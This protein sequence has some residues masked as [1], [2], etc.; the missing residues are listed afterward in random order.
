MLTTTT[1]SAP[2]DWDRLD[3]GKYEDETAAVARLLKSE[4]LGADA[5][6]V[7]AQAVTLV[8]E[9]RRLA[10]RQGVVE[11]FLQEFGLSTPEGLALMCLAE[12]L[13]RTPDEATRDALIAEKI[14]SADW[15]RHAGRSDS[16]FVNAGT[17]GLMLTGRLV[18]PDENAKRALA[19]FL[20]GL[21]GRIGEPVIRRAVATA[22]GVMGDQFVL[23]RTIQA[24]LKRA[25]RSG[26]VCSFDMLGEGARTYA[27]AERYEAAY[28]DAIAAVGEAAGGQGPEEGHGISVKLSAL[29][30][31]YEATQEARVF[32]EL[33]PR[34]LRIV[35]ASCEQ[36]INLTLDA[37][38][39]DRLA[40]SLK[41][42]E[43]LAEAPELHPEWR[44]LGLAVQA[45]QKR[46]GAVIDAVAD[47]ARRSGRRLMVRLVKGAYWDAEIKSAQVGGRP[48]YP[49]FTTKAATDLSYLVCADRLLAAAPS[50]YGQFAT[51][52]AHTL[53][54]VRRL[55]ERR[56]VRCERQRPHGRGEALHGAAG[57]RRPDFPLRIYA[58]VGGH[59]DLLP[60]L[61]R[62]LLENGANTSFVNRIVDERLPAQKNVTAPVAEAD[63]TRPAAEPRIALPAQLFGS[64]RLNSR[65][66]NFADGA[67]LR[68]LLDQCRAA[69][70]GIAPLAQASLRDVDHAL[71]QATRAQAAWDSRGSEQRVGILE[72]AADL[73]EV[74]RAELI[75]RCVLEAGRSVPDSASEVREAIDFLRYYAAQARIMGSALLLNGPTGERNTLRVRGR[76]V[77]ACISPWNFPI[78]IFTG[79]VSAA[80]VTGNA[81]LA[82]PAEQTPL[83]AALAVELLHRAGV[84]PEVLHLLPGGPQTGEALTGDP[85]IAGVVFTGSTQTARLIERKLAARSGAIATLIAETGGINVMI[86]DSSALA[87]QVV[88]DSVTSAF[89]SAGQRCSALRILLLRE[90]I[91]PT[92]LDL[93]AGQ[94]DELVIGPSWQLTTDVGPVIDDEALAALETYA[95]RVIVGARWQHRARVPAAI[96]S[97]RYFR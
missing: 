95:A 37:E 28:L 51:H 75:A 8:L 89:N 46:G 62:R 35:T 5:G 26:F 48:D 55:A 88:L 91:A 84:P 47:L 21:A 38:E 43:K 15:A 78:S 10:R 72:R 7:R 97:G 57:P 30:P 92:V 4:P 50:L 67:E 1:V 39:A 22:I 56:H 42:L 34:I 13:L 17:W 58:P 2:L 52:N 25:A 65:G 93:L 32:E 81:V 44:G 61:V 29:H 63:R 24:A 16:L 96:G 85:R 3:D 76:G 59:E 83:T 41:L 36:D 18:E 9:A 64:Q 77:F 33:Y 54:A 71:T 23:G 80:L 53:A 19:G 82:K 70:P 90:E 73:F 20:R 49:V 66:V 27:D 79:Q 14:G 31:R 60:Y 40:L 12:A 6:T 68:T 11:S 45:Y 87:E 74:H 69:V 94:M 86:V